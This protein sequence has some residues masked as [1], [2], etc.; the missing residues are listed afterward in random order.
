MNDARWRSET[1]VLG[2][3]NQLWW[4]GAHGVRAAGYI[5][6]ETGGPGNSGSCSGNVAFRTCHR[7]WNSIGAL[8]TGYSIGFDALDGRPA[9]QSFTYF[10]MQSKN[11]SQTAPRR[12]PQYPLTGGTQNTSAGLLPS[13]TDGRR[14]LGRNRWP[15][16]G[17]GPGTLPDLKAAS[18]YI[19]PSSKPWHR[20]GWHAY[21]A[22]ATAAW[23]AVSVLY[24]PVYG[25]IETVTG[26]AGQPHQAR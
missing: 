26:S 20:P 8:L 24:P 11:C 19:E 3:I 5:A 9:L 6:S 25:G 18:C 12:H 22:G 16:Q 10:G 1:R 7:R 23:V 17:S 4:P 13:C 14:R 15:L 2:E 21:F